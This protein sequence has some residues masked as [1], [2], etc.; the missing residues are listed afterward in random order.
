[1]IELYLFINLNSFNFS[2]KNSIRHNLSLHSKFLKIQNEDNKSCWWVVNKSVPL[3][4]N[5]K[6]KTIK[7][8]Q[9]KLK[10]KKENKKTSKKVSKLL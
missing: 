4:S 2:L 9:A 6:P 5:K 7:D 3:N 10:A 1:M 8:T